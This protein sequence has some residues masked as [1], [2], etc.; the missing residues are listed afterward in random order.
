MNDSNSQKRPDGS[1]PLRGSRNPPRRVILASH[2]IFT[3]YAHWMPNDPRGSG[4]TDLRK[5]E[6]KDL[7]EI[8][9]GRQFPQ[10]PRDAV[11]AFHTDAEPLLQHERIWFNEPMREIIANAFSEAAKRHGYTIW[12]CASARIMDTPSSAPIVIRPRSYGRISPM[13]RKSRCEMRSYFRITT[14][15]GR[16]GRTKFSSTPPKMWWVE[17]IM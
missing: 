17:S 4:S 5:D 1:L 14:P 10:P 11:R 9:P 7:G 8:L 13:L 3:G 2:L 12:A 15:C 6:L 16:I